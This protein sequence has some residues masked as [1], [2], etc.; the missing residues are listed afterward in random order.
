MMDVNIKMRDFESKILFFNGMYKLPVAAYP[1]TQYVI[2]HEAKRAPI[3]G[4]NGKDYLLRRLSDFKKILS[5]EVE[6]VEHIVQQIKIGFV[7]DAKTGKIT[8]VP[9]T[10]IKF[11]TDMADWLTDLQV[12]QASEMAKYGIPV[13]ES[14]NI[15]MSSNFSKLGSDGKPIYDGN[16]KVQKGPMYWKPEPQ[17]EAMLGQHIQENGP[18]A[19][20]GGEDGIVWREPA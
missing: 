9:Y 19:T 5:D 20:R 6:E 7:I 12:Y 2:E 10:E 13:K 11:L 15:V 4:A 17:L 1:S 18:M 14:Q 8:D 16:G 3:E